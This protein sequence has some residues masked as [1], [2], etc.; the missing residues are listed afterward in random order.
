MN[1]VL[2]NQTGPRYQLGRDFSVMISFDDHALATRAIDV[3]HLLGRKLKKEQGQLFHQWWNIETMAFTSLRE[4]AAAEAATA[5]M[6]ILS[7]HAAKELPEMVAAWLKRLV[8]LRKDRPGALVALLDSDLKTAEAPQGMISELSRWAASG[9]FDL[10]AAR[11]HGRQDAGA[12]QMAGE[13]ARQFVLARKNCARSGSLCAGGS[14]RPNLENRERVH[15][16]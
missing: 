13:A 3:L 15:P 4:L 12:A 2:K 1:L 7:L 14:S 11:G 6:I 16:R 5:D 9:H 8:E 10:F